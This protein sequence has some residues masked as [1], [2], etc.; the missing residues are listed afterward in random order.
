M[1][2]ILLVCLFLFTK[3]IIHSDQLTNTPDH[4]EDLLQKGMHVL[5]SQEDRNWFVYVICICVF[6][7]IVTL[8]LGYVST[9]IYS[10]YK[11]PIRS[12]VRIR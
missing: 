11:N 9:Y 2:N 3:K 4:A 8:Y 12:Y 6:D 1:N 5:K 10:T 7:S